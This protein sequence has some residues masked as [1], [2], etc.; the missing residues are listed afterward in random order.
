[1][2]TSDAQERPWSRAGSRACSSREEWRAP[3]AARHRTCGTV[4][5]TLPVTEHGPAI[6][7]GCASSWLSA[8]P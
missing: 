7:R 5:V 2:A 3:R 8:R 6:A 4:R 1:M